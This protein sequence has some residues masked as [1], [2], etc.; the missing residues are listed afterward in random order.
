MQIGLRSKIMYTEINKRLEEA[1]Q[2]VFRL[3]KIDSI[4]KG[5]KDE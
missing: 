1:Q 5:L 4:L 2:G 3:H